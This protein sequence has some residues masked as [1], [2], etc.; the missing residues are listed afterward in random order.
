VHPLVAEITEA[1]GS[2]EDPLAEAASVVRGAF[3]VDRVSIARLDSTALRFEIAADSG[4]D[5][6][7]PGTALPIDTCSYFARAVEGRA[8][9]EDDFDASRSFRRPL[10]SVVLAAGFHAGCSVPLRGEDG[11][12]GV[13]SLSAGAP[14]G[15]M[16]SMVERLEAVGDVLAHGI[17]PRA[18]TTPP[19]VLICHGDALVGRGL[20]RLVERG[21]GARAS[22]APTLADALAAVAAAPPDL[23]VCDDW[24]DGLRVDA[25]ARALREAGTQAPLLVVS[26]RDAPEN[27]RASLLAGAAGYL[28]RHDA[29]ARMGEALAALRSGRTLLP[30]PPSDPAP[31]LTERE[32]ELLE[33]LDE[34][35][36]FKQVALRLGI[37]EATVKTHGRNL[38]RK[39]G[40]TSRAEAVHAAR[41]QGLIA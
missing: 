5:L 8:F 14:R 40:A 29:V 15:D 10:D 30:A 33:A 38:F 19:S 17:E 37:S 32:R 34:G 2:T 9:H 4:A 20:A 25:V 11:P 36:R 13:V 41:D 39:L 6:L 1:L 12:I 22:V 35:L 27:V 18:A 28:A 7:A 21:D 3:E 31:Q 23:V 26:S 16:S 24:M